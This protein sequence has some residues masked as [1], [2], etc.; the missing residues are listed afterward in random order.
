M[1][2]D[3]AGLVDVDRLESAL[4]ERVRVV[5]IGWQFALGGPV[6]PITE[7]AEVV[8]R[9]P[10]ALIAVDASQVIGKAPIVVDALGVDIITASGR[11]WL[12]GLVARE[13]C[14]SGFPRCRNSALRCRVNSLA[15]RLYRALPRSSVIGP[16]TLQRKPDW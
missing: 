15:T 13:C 1:P 14:G 7:I 8:R 2:L 6:Q 11:K 3:G 10:P 5:S 16:D 12:R 9:R 4:D